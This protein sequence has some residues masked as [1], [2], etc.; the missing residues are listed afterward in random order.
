MAFAQCAL[1]N[2][3]YK[4][5]GA[6]LLTNGGADKPKNPIVKAFVFLLLGKYFF[7]SIVLQVVM[8]FC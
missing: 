3:N 7:T 4:I 6:L 5:E 2:I 1:N 8:T